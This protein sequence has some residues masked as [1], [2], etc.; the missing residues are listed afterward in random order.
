MYFLVWIL[1]SPSGRLLFVYNGSWRGADDGH[2]QPS[3]ADVDVDVD[4]DA[5]LLE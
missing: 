2:Q 5:R 1:H 4:V 3:R